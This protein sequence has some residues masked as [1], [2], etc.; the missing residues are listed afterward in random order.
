MEIENEDEKSF[1]SF[2]GELDLV[3]EEEEDNRISQKERLAKIMEVINSTNKNKD[4]NTPE[5]NP[6]ILRGANPNVLRAGQPNKTSSI[7]NDK[8][9]I[10]EPFDPNFNLNEK[11]FFQNKEYASRKNVSLFS[12]FCKVKNL[13]LTHIIYAQHT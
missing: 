11:Y 10:P 7:Q 2:Q 5:E 4:E 13:T 6:Q 8:N 12:Y 3:K 1:D 9:K